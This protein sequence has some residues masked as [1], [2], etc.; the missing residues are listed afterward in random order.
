MRLARELHDTF[1]Q[2]VQ[3]SKMVADDALAEDSDEPRMNRDG[4][5]RQ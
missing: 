3:G 1:I 4:L 5:G 2:T